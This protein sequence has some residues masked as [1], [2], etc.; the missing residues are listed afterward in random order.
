M[1]DAGDLGKLPPEIRK[2]IYSYLLVEDETIRIKRSIRA[3]SKHKYDTAALRLRR[4]KRSSQILRVNMLIREEA[5]QILYG[6]NKFEF[7]NA[8]ALYHFLQQVGDARRHLRHVAIYQDGLMF[9]RS[10]K[11]MQQSIQI[12]ASVGGLRTLEVSHDALCGSGTPKTS[13]K[14]LVQHCKPLLNAL[15]AE[16]ITK[17]LNSSVLDIIDIVLPRSYCDDLPELCSEKY[18]HPRRA[19]ITNY[20]TNMSRNIMSVLTCGCHCRQ[21]VVVNKELKQELKEEIAK[22]LNIQLP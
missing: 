7:F 17:G 16:F 15:N 3:K 1:A 2:E 11:S 21:A 22:Q 12:L 6:C 8:G 20:A 14:D 5:A 18:E 4:R 10:W 19:F 9:M 13:I